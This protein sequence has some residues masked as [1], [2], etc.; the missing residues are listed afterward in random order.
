[1]HGTELLSDYAQIVLITLKDFGGVENLKLT[2]IQIPEISKNEVL[3]KTKA[4]SINPVD[5]KTRQG[6]A[7]ANTLKDF[8]PIILGWDISGIIEN[9]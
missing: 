8:N 7:L 4:I 2:E 5:I 3:V 6:E 1:M 9:Y